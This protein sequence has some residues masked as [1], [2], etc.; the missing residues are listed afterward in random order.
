MRRRRD[1]ERPDLDVLEKIWVKR[2]LRRATHHRD[3]VELRDL[4]DRLGFDDVETMVACHERAEERR[5]VEH[6]RQRP[7]RIRDDLEGLREWCDTPEDLAEARAQVAE[8]YGF[9]DESEMFA[10]L[11]DHDV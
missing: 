11:A 8:W 5:R 3:D 10:W 9:A 4:A 1:G 6:E 7:R 2:V